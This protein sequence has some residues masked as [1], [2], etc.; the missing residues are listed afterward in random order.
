MAVAVVTDSAA[1][2]PADLAQSMGIT[3][4]P[5]R[6]TIGDTSYDEG[7]IPLQEVVHRF[8]EGIHTAGPSP[9][10]LSAILGQA[11]AGDGVVVLT[12]SER[13]SSTYKSALLAAEMV[14]FQAEVVDTRSAAGGQSLVV[15]AAARAAA[16]GHD[17]AEVVATAERVRALVRMVAAVETLDY[18]VKGGRLPELAGRAGRHLGVRPIFELRSDGIKALRPA[19]SHDK[20][21]DALLG[22][23]RRSRPA[24]GGLL[25]LAVSHALDPGAGERLVGVIRAEVE[26]ASW[27]IESFGPVMVAHTGPGV[28]GLA[29]YWEPGSGSGSDDVR[30]T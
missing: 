14:G 7:E 9:G 30:R 5:M 17:L 26:P 13:M 27:L 29:W 20:A 10:K 6:L 23:W 16:A 11:E 12:V 4:V 25:H 21:L 3:V 2:I 15:M 8:D 28:I 19:L 24:G 18:L 1:A 22:H